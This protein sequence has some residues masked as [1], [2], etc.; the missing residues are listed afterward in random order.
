MMQSVQVVE[1]FVYMCMIAC[2]CM[3]VLAQERCVS[4]LWSVYKSQC[5]GERENPR[6]IPQL[7]PQTFLCLDSLIAHKEM[8]TVHTQSLDFQACRQMHME[9]LLTM[10][11]G[12]SL[13]CP[14]SEVPAPRCTLSSHRGPQWEMGRNSTPAAGS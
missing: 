12:F 9:S 5:L 2:I 10:N 1:S 8:F 11:R 4:G 6:L 7:F 3:F 13:Q 14:V